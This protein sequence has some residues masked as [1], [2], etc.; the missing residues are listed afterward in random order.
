MSRQQTSH[1][2]TVKGEF[3]YMYTFAVKLC[4]CIHCSYQWFILV[5]VFVTDW[6]HWPPCSVWFLPSVLVSRSDSI[7]FFTSLVHYLQLSQS[8]H[9][10]IIIL[11]YSVMK[12]VLQST[13]AW[14]TKILH[15]GFSSQSHLW[16]S[17]CLFILSQ[18]S[19]ITLLY[20][21]HIFVEH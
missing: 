17:A 14:K 19:Q 7:S 20:D 21:M 9:T 8:S 10:V 5:L 16:F 18:V 2:C 15:I 12:L 11:Y 13:A 4:A 3:S 1:Q 6:T